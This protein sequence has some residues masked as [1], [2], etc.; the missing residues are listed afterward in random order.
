LNAP[1]LSHTN[2]IGQ[3][4]F[5]NLIK[6]RNELD[7]ISVELDDN[8]TEEPDLDQLLGSALMH[9]E[10]ARDALDKVLSLIEG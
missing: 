6:V 7:E 4:D 1:T 9:V 5:L 8:F 3:E 2:A 10:S